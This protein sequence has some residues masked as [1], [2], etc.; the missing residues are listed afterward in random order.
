MK[1]VIGVTHNVTA[2]QCRREVTQAGI[3]KGGCM[4]ERTGPGKIGRIWVSEDWRTVAQRVEND[5]RS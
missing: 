5:F 2:R 1:K 3:T 4:E